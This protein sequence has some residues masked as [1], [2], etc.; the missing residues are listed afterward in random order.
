MFEHLKLPVIVL[1]AGG[2]AGVVI[3][4]LH[5]LDAQILGVTDPA[6]ADGALGPLETPVIGGDDAILAF[7]SDK[8]LLALGLGS[9]GST[10]ARSALFHKYRAAGFRFPTLVHPSAVISPRVTHGE[11]VQVMAGAVLQVGTQLGDNCLINSSASIDHDCIIGEDVH[12]APGAVLS[13]GVRVG[14]GAHIGIG[15]KII[16]SIAI[17]ADAVIG[18]GVT[19]LGDVAPG[20]T[21]RMDPSRV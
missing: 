9:T 21:L 16:Q 12:V 5:A 1:G 17:G 3:D 11:G 18:A 20:V 7:G 6:L 14:R 15:A 19:V 10:Q 4:M 2:H 8:V 13:G